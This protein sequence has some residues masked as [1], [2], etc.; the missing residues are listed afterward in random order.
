MAWRCR[1]K[2]QGDGIKTEREQEKGRATHSNLPNG[3][4]DTQ[5]ILLPP[6]QNREEGGQEREGTETAAVEEV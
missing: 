6:C 3:Q 4:R 1:A 2:E 5:Q